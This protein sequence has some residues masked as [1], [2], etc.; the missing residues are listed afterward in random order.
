MQSELTKLTKENEKLDSILNH[1]F[2]SELEFDINESYK[3]IKDIEFKL[4]DLKSR[5]AENVLIELGPKYLNIE[6][7]NEMKKLY[8]NFYSFIKKYN[9]NDEKVKNLSEEELDKIYAIS[10]FIKNNYIEM[11]NNIMFNMTWTRDEYKFIKGAFRNRMEYSGN[12][13]FNSVDLKEKYLDKWEDLDKLLPKT[14]SEFTIAI[15]IKNVIMMYHFLSTFKIKGITED[16]YNFIE[17]LKKIGDVNK[18]FNAYT[19]AKERINTD[20]VSWT[21]A[22]ST[23]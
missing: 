8:T 21:S 6:Y 20:F 2:N 16:Y 11:I 7:Q 18:L 4:E 5:E 3:S 1:D 19:I 9:P 10:Q 13:I 23:K 12:D 14:T 22:L 15:D 17:I